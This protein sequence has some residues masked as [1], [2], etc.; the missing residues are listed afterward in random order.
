MELD[1]IFMDS[2]G[3]AKSSWG[4]VAMLGAIP[5]VVVIIAVILAVIGW[6]IGVA[7]GGTGAI[8]II[9]IMALVI[10][11]IALLAGLIYTGYLFRVMKATLA[12]INELPSFD[13]FVG[14]IID[15]LKVIVVGIIYGIIAWVITGIVGL[16]VYFIAAIPL[17]AL[18]FGS[19][20]MSSYSST[21]DISGM[22]IGLWI[23]LVVMAIGMI[24]N[25]VIMLLFAIIIPLAIA[26]MAS[27]GSIGAAFSISSI[28]GRLE[29]IRW[30]KAVLWL[31]GL[32]FIMMI[33]ALVSIVLFG[34]VIG[35]IVVP[36][37]VMPFMS[38]FYYR[39][40]ALLYL[41]GE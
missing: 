4:K 24:I 18:I 14:M 41:E 34:I 15:G 13:D 11:V 20:A 38:I 19:M 3:Y 5:L 31:V 23:A 26:N 33:A 9:G 39:S 37:L 8:I 7:A 35:I 6:L 28:R 16:V 2:F 36:L 27:E 10:F 21:P 32:Y 22:F 17:Y 30:T 40:A 25:V 12:G 1:E 29:N